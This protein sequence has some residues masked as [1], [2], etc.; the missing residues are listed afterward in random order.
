MEILLFS[1]QNLS[2]RIVST[3]DGS[4]GEWYPI[5]FNVIG[6][7]SIVLQFLIF[8]MKKQR[9]IVMVGLFSDIGWL[10]YFVLQGDLISST[11]NIIVDSYPANWEEI[12]SKLS[13]SYIENWQGIVAII[14]DA[15]ISAA[16]KNNAIRKKY[17]VEYDFMLNTWYPKLRAADI[18]IERNQLKMSA[19]EVKKSVQNNP[20]QLSLDDIYI[21]ALTYEKGSKEWDELI[22]IAVENYP[23]SPEARVNAA[24]VAMANGDYTAAEQYLQGVPA[25]MPE[26]MN[27]RGIL[28]MAQGDYTK[29]LD[30][31]QQALSAGVTEAAYNITLVRELMNAAQ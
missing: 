16:D 31:F 17:P 21:I 18:S 15:T 1:M 26:A 29:A 25:N 3:L 5:L 20:S 24:N 13:S 30:L 19:A 11:A 22:L 10:L 6:V 27:S 4:M 2:N 23:Q 14:D 28:A 9:G 8:Q 7:I 12:K